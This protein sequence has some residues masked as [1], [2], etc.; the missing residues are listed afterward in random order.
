MLIKQ[1]IY[2]LFAVLRI[3]VVSSGAAVVSRHVCD[4]HGWLNNFITFIT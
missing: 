3:A 1:E 2:I 4:G